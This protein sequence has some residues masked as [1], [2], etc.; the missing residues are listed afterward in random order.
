MCAIVVKSNRVIAVGYNK[1]KP[2]IT[3]NPNYHNNA[4]HAELQAILSVDPEK[5]K[6]ATI[7]VGGVSRCGNTILSKPCPLCQN[8][9]RE[10]GI[11]A[12]VWHNKD[13]EV[14]TWKVS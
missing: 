10:M 7:Y 13:N 3:K 9:L 11:K 6:G 14:E 8:L 2:G 5:L 1:A 12:A 4:I